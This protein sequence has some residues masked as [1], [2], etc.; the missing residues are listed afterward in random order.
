MEDGEGNVIIIFKPL[1]NDIGVSTMIAF[2]RTCLNQ[3]VVIS[4]FDERQVSQIMDGLSR[5]VVLSLQLNWRMFEIS[6]KSN[7]DLI[8]NIVLLSCFAALRRATGGGERKWLKSTMQ[9]NLS[10]KLQNPFVK[11][12]GF[13]S[14]LKL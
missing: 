4:H 11:K 8:N 6:P 2:V 12:E 13:F 14:K 3:S 7:L 5:D 9:E 1:L 10:G